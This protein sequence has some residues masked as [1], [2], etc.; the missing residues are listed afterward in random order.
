L[1]AEL[2]HE[3]NAVEPVELGSPLDKTCST[4]EDNRLRKDLEGNVIADMNSLEADN[5]FQLIGVHALNR[6]F[7]PEPSGLQ[8]EEFSPTLSKPLGHN[9]DVSK[10]SS[11]S[12]HQNMSRTIRTRQEI[13]ASMIEGS[14]I[15]HF[16]R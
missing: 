16:T 9:F 6:T 14:L 12:Q 15:D 7:S 10:I 1:T 8:K 11:S 5:S 3:N 13:K 2:I 4:T